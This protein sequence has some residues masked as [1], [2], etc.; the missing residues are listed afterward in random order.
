MVILANSSSVLKCYEGQ[1]NE[2]PPAPV[3]SGIPQGN[4]LDLLLF[5]AYIT[6]LPDII[7]SIAYL[8]A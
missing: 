5:V 7:D 1:N 3:I 4:V 6:D 2:R 8:F